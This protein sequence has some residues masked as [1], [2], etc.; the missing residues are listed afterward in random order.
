MAVRN[1]RATVSKRKHQRK[2]PE[3]QKS[4]NA[5]NEAAAPGNSSTASALLMFVDEAH[6]SP[7]AHNT[8]LDEWRVSGKPLRV[9]NGEVWGDCGPTAFLRTDR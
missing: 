2:E 9:L 6:S 8:K 3:R 5:D 4:R 7:L 1:L